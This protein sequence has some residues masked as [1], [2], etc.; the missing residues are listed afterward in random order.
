MRVTLLG[1]GTSCGVPALGCT[2]EVCTSRDPHDARLRSSALVETHQT[3]LLIDPGPDF[4]QQMLHQPFRKIDG[5]LVTHSHYDHIGGIDDIRPYCQ[6][7]RVHVYANEGTAKTIR[8][9]FPYFFA[10]HRYPGVPNIKLH[11]ILPHVPLLIGDLKVVPIEVMHGKLPILGYRIGRFAY[12]TDMKTMAAEEYDY[13]EGVDILVINAL[14]FGPEHMSHQLVSD[15]I[16]VAG[17]VGAKRTYLTH[18]CHEIG[19]H[20]EVDHQLP[21]NIRMAYDGLVIKL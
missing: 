6:F 21:Y 5:L 4:R 3:R 1:T 8:H 7:G 12:I 15:A 16:K 14:R 19:L 17:R 18:A 10:E 11:E 9:N 2:C 13:L 20:S